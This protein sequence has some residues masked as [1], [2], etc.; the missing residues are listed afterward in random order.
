MASAQPT[1]TKDRL[2]IVGRDL[3][4][5]KGFNDTGIQ[6]VLKIS[7]APKGSFYHHFTS[8]EDFGLQVLDG[9]ARDSYDQ[10]DAS[11]SDPSRTPLDRLRVFFTG[12]RDIFVEK[13]CRGGCLIG[14]FGQEL[15]DTHDAFR[16]RV[17]AHMK[18]FLARLVRC[19]V[20][21]RESGEL[22]ELVAV[23]DYGEVLFSAWHGAMLRMKVQKSIAPIDA[24]LR[25]YFSSTPTA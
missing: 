17:E 9:F 11:L 10:L 13:G 23:A 6:E 15:S 14:N 20:E 22:S 25:I 2:L 7:G 19:L 16:A 12:Q 18:Q 4:W 1:T 24:F 5:S 21:A 3:L 8:K